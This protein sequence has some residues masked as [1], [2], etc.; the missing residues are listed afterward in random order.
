MVKFTFKASLIALLLFVPIKAKEAITSHYNSENDNLYL[1]A[2]NENK[3]T[4][5]NIVKYFHKI[6]HKFKFPKTV[7]KQMILESGNLKSTVCKENN[8]LFGFRKVSGRETTAIK[9]KL[10]NN[11]SV[12]NTFKESIDDYILWQ[13][14]H[15]T[16]CNNEKQYEQYLKKHYAS[17]GNNYIETIH[18]IDL[19]K[20]F[21][22]RQ[23]DSLSIN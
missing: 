20:F 9:G 2:E 23:L 3:L 5:S 7:L 10:L 22:N 16:A 17:D 11:Y 18:N 14:K 13:N 1:K 15:L 12:Y 4:K 6:K 19:G 8:N 21:K